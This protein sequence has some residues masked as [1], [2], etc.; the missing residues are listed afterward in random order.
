MESVRKT[1][2]AGLY[3]VVVR[4]PDGPAVDCID[5]GASVIIDAERDRRRAL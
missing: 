5:E 3:E 2:D 4:A 1:P